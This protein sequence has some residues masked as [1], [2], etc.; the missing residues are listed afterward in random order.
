MA[1]LPRPTIHTSSTS[2]NASGHQAAANLDDSQ[3]IKIVIELVKF[4]RTRIDDLHLVRQAID[5]KLRKAKPANNVDL[6]EDL[7]A[8]E[9]T[10]LQ[11]ENSLFSALLGLKQTQ[12][13]MN[14]RQLMKHCKKI[15]KIFENVVEAEDEA[16]DYAQMA[17]NPSMYLFSE[18]N[19]IEIM[20]DKGEKLQV[21]KRK[22]SIN[23]KFL[24]ATFRE[25]D[26]ELNFCVAFGIQCARKTFYVE[27]TR[28]V[29][30]LLDQ[31]ELY[32]DKQ[33]VFNKIVKQL[34]DAQNLRRLKC[35]TLT[36]KIEKMLNY[37]LMTNQEVSEHRTSYLNKRANIARSAS[38]SQYRAER[39]PQISAQQAN[40]SNLFKSTSRNSFSSPTHQ[41]QH[42]HQHN[43][44]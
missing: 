40:R 1:Q 17:R 33:A 29:S 4:V 35:I 31:N 19:L 14:K 5:V 36:S 15:F 11:R 21:Y 7:K 16:Q 43:Q 10:R 6:F 26:F 27:F 23:A 38:A 42:Q 12:S 41:A 34:T 18:L 8:K 25:K 32:A 20:T 9:I 22:I 39:K 3:S 30:T 2:N 28:A 13:T 44:Q 24:E 37:L